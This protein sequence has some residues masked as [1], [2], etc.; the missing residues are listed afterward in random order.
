[1]PDSRTQLRALAMLGLVML[2][3]AGNS[4]VGRAVRF[5]I[6]PFTL[7]F[8]RWTGALLVLLLFA[9]PAIWR[10]RAEILR[11]WKPI[12]VL[13]IIGVGTF[14]TLLY[15]GL[16][17]TTATNALLLQAALPALVMIFDRGIF[18]TRHNRWQIAGVWL[19]MVG[20]VAIVFEGD[21]AVAM[22][23]HFGRG[24]VL[25]LL[26]VTAWALYTVLL[27]L[28]PAISPASFVAAT[29]AVGVVVLA[30]LAAGEWLAG[31]TVN[32]KPGVIGAF[33]YVALLPSLA[34]YFIYNWATAQV[35]PARAGQALTLMPVC[36]AFLSALLL[37]ETLH[38]YH[39]A[40]IVLILAGIGLGVLA[41]RGKTSLAHRQGGR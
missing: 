26:A 8:V 16:R 18:G 31:L 17:E 14:N 23:L 33:L 2:F 27:R 6:P 28:R 1:M 22:K 37:G 32:W 39:L 29:F 34:A 4:I 3:W 38:A 10:E 5:D 35:G 40:G 7:A 24:D 36:G 30:P 41:M 9:G 21:P 19:S 12:L 13:G 15:V 11:G 25:I 20:V